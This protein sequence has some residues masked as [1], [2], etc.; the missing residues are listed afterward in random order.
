M[1]QL[2]GL[3][4]GASALIALASV[5]YADN[6]P[7]HQVRQA[8]PISLGTS[9]GNIN[10]I[11]NL[12]CCS[13]TLGSL[14]KVG[15]TQYILSNN[16][17]LALSNNGHAGDVI[18]QPGMVDVNCAQITADTV[19]NLSSFV[20]IVKSRTANNLVDGAI[21]QVVS[22]AVSGT[23][24][25]L[26]VGCLAA[27]TASATVGL[28]VRKSGRT[29]GFTSGSVSAV[30]VSILV[31]YPSSCGGSGGKAARFNQ[32]IQIGP[33]SFSGGGDSGSLIVDTANPPHAV[34]LLFAGSSSATFA[35]TI[36]NVLSAFGAQMVSCNGFADST[37]TTGEDWDPMLM[38][39]M[40]I[41]ANLES[42]LMSI[43]REIP[44]LIG[45]GIGASDDPSRPYGLEL[46]LDQNDT[47]YASDA[48]R[49]PTE[50]G[51]LDVTVIP[52]DRPV[53]F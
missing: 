3:A 26:D 34:G 38:D 16:H 9:G 5:L 2:V 42:Y 15:T 29:T 11:S 14:V 25:I 28:S 51:R 18:T 27:T 20:T 39:A 49:L 1:K 41:Q 52:M 47:R 48:M 10:D 46:Y 40:A 33:G 8:R 50:W 53:A 23:G 43:H 12:F 37:P 30:N 21:A 24:N 31:A 32:Q 6:G 13:G 17:V 7:N 35:N 19:A 22:G 36:G 45:I 4:L 44:T